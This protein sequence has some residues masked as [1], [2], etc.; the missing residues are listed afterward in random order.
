MFGQVVIGPP[1]SGKSTYCHGM[2]Q[3][4]SAIGRKCSIINLDPANENLPYPTCS[5]DIRDYIRLEEI[6]K[7]HNLGPNGALMY[8]MESLDRSALEGLADIWTEI[9]KSDYLIFDCPGQV[10]LFTHHNSFFQIFRLLTKKSDARLCSVSLVD[11]VHLTSASQYISM[12]LLSLRAMVQLELPHVNVISKIDLLSSYR[13]LPMRLDYYLEVQDLRQLI[14][15]VEQESPT[16]LGVNYVRLTELIADLV[17]DYNLVSFEVLAI[18]NKRSMIH[19]LQVIDKANGYA[20]GSLELGGDHIWAE[21]VRN[22]S[23]Y[24][25]VDLHDR[26]VE[27]KAAYD[28]EERKE[29]QEL[30]EPVNDEDDL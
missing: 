19:L 16:V 4:M 6:M 29:E 7:V 12:L 15:L 5:F 23:N 25:D 10:E 9:G 8:A 30:Q 14:P 1:G 22:S 27:N 20:Y 21:A 13:E 28:E 26:W 18:E 3:F 11:S 17:E 24:D 2:L